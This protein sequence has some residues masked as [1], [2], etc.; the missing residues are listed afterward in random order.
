[1]VGFGWLMARK[2]GLSFAPAVVAPLA[3]SIVLPFAWENTLSGF[4]SQHYFMVVFTLPALWLL[5]TREPGTW[6]WW[7]GVFF[8][9]AGLF[10]VGAGLIAP[11]AICVF[12]FFRIVLAGADWRKLWPT[13]VVGSFL[14]MVGLVLKVEVP[15]HNLL[16]AHS[17]SEFLM[18]L[19]K[20]L[21]WPWIVLPPYAIFNL[22]PMLLLVWL[23]IRHPDTRT[24]ATQII[25]LTGLWT[26]LQCLA[27]AYARGAKG[28][29]PQWRYMDTTSFLMIVNSLSLLLIWTRY[30][31]HLRWPRYLPAAAT[32]WI[33]GA[34]S[35]ALL[36]TYQAMRW[37]IPF[38][39]T[40]HHMAEVTLRGYLET[41]DKR[42]FNVRKIYLA[43]F[44]G[45]PTKS[46]DHDDKLIEY[47]NLPHVRSLLP[48]NNTFLPQKT[49]NTGQLLQRSRLL[50][51]WAEK[52]TSWGL[53]IFGTGCAAIMFGLIAR[54]SRRE[55]DKN[56]SSQ[57]KT[58]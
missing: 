46:Q 25:L 51:L 7:C 29:H 6:Q 53:P 37:D 13:I 16:K 20:Y 11:A 23:Y 50:S 36:L 28:A 14:A 47:I 57:P 10:T 55:S 33:T 1:M 9:A 22:F 52:L 43:R 3:L 41:G 19:G 34:V 17:I 12:A 27:A 2:I 30:R 15:H 49:K 8:A 38:R 44:E 45:D 35:G 31:T 56:K 18:S 42:Y 24:Q 40:L 4:H 26:C 21:S 48:L 54:H 5:G 32:L 39:Q 58:N